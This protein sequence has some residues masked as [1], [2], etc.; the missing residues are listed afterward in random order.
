MIPGVS[1]ID[2]EGFI[3]LAKSM[4]GVAKIE[5]GALNGIKSMISLAM[6]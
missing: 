4:Q 1:K 2:T 3:N 6:V 5:L